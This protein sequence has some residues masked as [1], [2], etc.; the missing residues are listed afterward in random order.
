MKCARPSPYC[1]ELRVVNDCPPRYRFVAGDCHVSI[2]N[3]AL[4][5]SSQ[6]RA[7]PRLRTEALYVR[8][9][10]AIPILGNAHELIRS[11]LGSAMDLSIKKHKLRENRKP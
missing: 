6:T 9:S 8:R 2:F 5:A 11:A 7:S 1:S 4:K 10:E 3:E